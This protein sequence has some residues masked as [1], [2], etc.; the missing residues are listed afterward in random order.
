MALDVTL[1]VDLTI[2]RSLGSCLASLKVLIAPGGISLRLGIMARTI[3]GSMI[4]NYR[5]SLLL[6]AVTP[7][8]ST[9]L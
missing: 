6:E 5:R 2:G 8:C 7:E 1:G 9:K 4:P 3:Y